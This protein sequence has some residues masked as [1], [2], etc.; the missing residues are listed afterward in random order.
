MSGSIATAMIISMSAAFPASAEDNVEKYPYT[1]F[2]ASSAE[3]AI[4]VNAGNFCVN[5]NVA[6]N[7]T[8]VS[9]GNMNINGIKT[10]N[11]AEDMIYVFDKIDATYFSSNN[12]DEHL[13][14][15]TL[16]EMNTNINTP[17][18]V[19]GNATLTG[20]ININTALKA[21]EDVYIN[22]EVMNTNNSMIFSKYGDITIDSHNVNLSGLVYAPFGDVEITAQN[23]NLNNVVIIAN[24]ITI[25]SPNVNA[26]YSSNMAEFTG[27]VSE[28]LNIPNEEWQY[29]K[30]ENDNDFPDFFEDDNNWSK[31]LDTDGDR[32]PDCIEQNIGS[33]PELI[34]SDSDGL[35]DFYEVFVAYT[36]PKMT[37]TDENGINDGDE[38]FDEDGLTN[39][40]EYEITSDLWNENSDDDT[41]N[42]GEEVNTYGTDPLKNDTDE[43][44]LEDGD[45]VYLG[46]EPTNPDTDGDG[47][48]DGNEK[49]DQTF[50]HIV[51][52][53]DCAV[54]EV[55]VS[56]NGTGN[57]QN[58][59]SVNSIMN[60][61]ILCSDVV[62]LVG[63]PFS[64]ESSSQFDSATIAFK[65]DQ[66]KLG[67]TA[68]DNLM[69]LWYD[70]E[71]NEFVEL[72]TI[73][74]YENSTVSIE[75]THFSRY[76][77]VD[78]NKWFE[79]WATEFNYNPSENQPGTPTIRYNTV[80]AIDCS[81]SMSSYDPISTAS[82]IDSPSEALFS[83][84][85]QRI[86]AAEG[87]I[88]NMNPVDKA[89]IVLFTDSAK[90]AAAMTNDTYTLKLALQKVTSSG[91]TSFNAAI[92]TSISAFNTADIKKTNTNNRIILLSDGG[93]SVSDSILKNAKDKGIKI[94]TIGLG[95]Y[96]DDTQLKYIS[97]YTGGEFFKA[98]TA[99]DLVDLYTEVG[100]DSDFD[101][102]DTDSDGLY[103]AVEASGIRLQNGK[104]LKNDYATDTVY[105]DP[106]KND[107]DG[108]GL[109][110]GEEIDPTIRWTEKHYNSSEAPQ[111]VIIKQ[112]YFVMISDPSNMDSDYDGMND[113]KDENRLDNSVTATLYTKYKKDGK[114]YNSDVTY[115][116]DLRNFFKDSTKYNSSLSTFSSILST[117]SYE[118]R[119]IQ[120]NGERYDAD[121]ILRNRGFSQVEIYDL[122]DV[123][124]IKDNHVSKMFI[125]KKEVTY[126]DNMK[127]I[128][129]IVIE[130]T[131]GSLEQWS[132]NFDIGSTDQLAAYE[133]WYDSKE[134]DTSAFDYTLNYLLQNDKDEI[135]AFSDW[136]TPENHKGFDIVANRFLIY[137]DEYI[138]NYVISSKQNTVF[139]ITGHSRGA[140][141]SNTLSA[142]LID[143]GYQTFTYT[144]A[145]PNTTTKFSANFTKYNSIFNIINNDDFVPMLPIEDWGFTRYGLTAGESIASNYEKEWEDMMDIMDYNPDTKGLDDTIKALG[146][147]A[148]DSDG[149]YNRNNLY[150]FTCDCHGDGTFN[151]ETT[152]TNRGES[153]VS[154]EEAKNKIPT[155]AL[156]YC[157]INDKDVP[158]GSKKA[159]FTV[160]QTPAY[161]MQLIAATMSGDLDGG[162]FFASLNI[163]DRYENA[164]KQLI[165]TR[166]GGVK[167][168][169]YLQGY[170]ILSTH[171]TANDFK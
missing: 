97:D 132:S 53:D 145:S 99:E 107:T 116:F 93:S 133:T 137:I 136:K 103:D 154:R 16:E 125:G 74:D 11:A 65:I 13:E 130:G 4:T 92:T 79:A 90:I 36:D 40:E 118:T 8:I 170:Y 114:N 33:N 146:E 45:E 18:E 84:T 1:F 63:E 31:L 2:A 128:I 86:E 48:L 56:M 91:G 67:D 100:F 89:A 135:V 119:Y 120:Y 38:D 162:V 23:L 113:D 70:E 166:I 123:D 15:Y 30:D 140:A 77:V 42:D 105:A 26:N 34:D 95:S 104:I 94:Y 138:D 101:V 155:N 68:F 44:G 124:T 96:S 80:L 152:I 69:F 169:H 122:A 52:N 127:T 142:Y 29:M 66:S 141:I 41:L 109:Y 164:K 5:G 62:G 32:L 46:T 117:T 158:I 165:D 115:E 19:K 61:D 106:L 27:N 160:C 102:T 73:F 49:Y 60:S 134:D 37:D 35:D 57:I 126:N 71:N 171:I 148:K 43:D 21:F 76:M 75:T 17:T 83:K 39:L 54:D 111:S 3:G 108:D 59:T 14:D 47:I 85:C 82:G 161:F 81:G 149:D 110:D 98:Y 25:N 163:A 51:E 153:E 87:F 147:L 168:P 157:I 9:S 55:I 151:N 20:N 139:Y 7:G 144:F 64:I 129:S 72:E 131:E 143:E 6:T 150:K 10:E 167:H 112:Y 159:D 22:G 28:P 88:D 58:N 50:T 121:D 12:F 24:T 156:P 78:K